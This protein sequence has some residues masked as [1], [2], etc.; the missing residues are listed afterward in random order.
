MHGIDISQF[1]HILSTTRSVRR[2]LD[3]DRAIDRKVLLACIDN[4]VQA[5]TGL[6]GESWRFVIVDDAQ[7][8]LR[9]RSCI[10]KC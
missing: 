8:K 9:W 10:H 1:D 2:N 7:A 3:F 5:P 6:A 4:A